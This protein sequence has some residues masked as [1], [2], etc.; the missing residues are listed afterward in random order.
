[1]DNSSSLYDFIVESSD[2]VISFDSEFRYTFAN[3]AALEFLDRSYEDVIGSTTSEILGAAGEEIENCLQKALS[4]HQKV[5]VDIEMNFPKHSAILNCIFTPIFGEGPPA[6]WAICRE[7]TDFRKSV[8]NSQIRVKQH[9]SQ[10]EEQKNLF[11]SLF[12]DIPDIMVFADPDRRIMLVNRAFERTFGYKTQDVLGHPTKML[13]AEVSD[14]NVK[15]Q[16]R[17]NKQAPKDLTPYEMMYR[18]ASGEFFTGLTVGSIVRST[19]GKVIGYLGCVTDL[20]EQKKL[21]EALE[22]ERV[23]NIHASK[24]ATLGEM[25]GGI[26]HEINNP[27]A[28]IKGSCDSLMRKLDRGKLDKEI[29]S[30]RLNTIQSTITRI[31][32]I[33]YGLR[34]YSHDSKLHDME[35]VPIS[36]I[37][38][39]TLS[40]CSEKLKNNDVDIKLSIPAELKAECNK[41]QISQVILNLLSNS[42]D[43]VKDLDEKWVEIEAYDVDDSIVI[44]VTDSGGGISPEIHNRLMEPFFT[45][46]TLGKGTGLGLS[47]V[48]GLIEAH[49]GSIQLDPR[50][51]NTRFVIHF[52]VR[53]SDHKDNAA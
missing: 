12:N 53:Q 24:M 7:V 6:L 17:Y 13:Y 23:K 19:D 51:K 3:Q 36:E 4:T 47:I 20:T 11:E 46:K 40:F 25:A 43:A 34:A 50:C 45:T 44:T 15:T 2:I 33:T 1:M 39:E 5:V 26:A 49:Q 42:C 14:F 22:I 18:K 29:L 52:P 8:E 35:E 41:I 10:L 21:E 9:L 28:I 37:I 38:D 31:E 48:K 30:S 16:K 32:K 27:L